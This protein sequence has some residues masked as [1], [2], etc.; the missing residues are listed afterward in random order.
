MQAAVTVLNQPLTALL[1][2]GACV[3][4][5]PEQLEQRL[6]LCRSS[7]N[8]KQKLLIKRIRFQTP[9][10]TGQTLNWTTPIRES[11]RSFRSETNKPERNLRGTQEE[12]DEQSH[13][14]LR[15]WRHAKKFKTS[16]PVTDLPSPVERVYPQGDS[17]S[18]LRSHNQGSHYQNHPGL[19]ARRPVY[20]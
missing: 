16:V 13:L 17:H 7:S 19:A 15:Q 3:S 20:S 5:A 9:T 10:L 6:A 18:S 4:L 8:F 12:P 2:D 14:L 11:E 1:Q